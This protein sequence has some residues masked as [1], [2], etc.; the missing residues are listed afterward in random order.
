MGMFKFLLPAETPPADAEQYAHAY[1]QSGPEQTP[2]PTSIQ[3]TGS[4]L[5][6]ER[7]VDESAAFC[8]PWSIFGRGRLMLTTGT[9]IARPTPYCLSVE[10]ARGRVNL[11]RSQLN[12]WQAGGLQVPVA[13]HAQI[14]EINR[15]FARVV[16]QEPG[17][18]ADALAEVLLAK[19]LTA[20]DELV[21]LYVDQVLDARL[22][23]QLPASRDAS[24]RP[25][26]EPEVP[27]QPR[28]DTS[29]G[30]RLSGRPPDKEETDWFRTAFNTVQ[31]AIP[32]NE[33]EPEEG[34]IDWG[35]TDAVYAWAK[36]NGLA[37]V[38]GPVID[39]SS[40]SLPAWLWLY[41][42]NKDAILE[43]MVRFTSAAV[44]R[45]RAS[46]SVWE[47]TAAANST[48]VLS[49]SDEEA[50]QITAILLER[51]RRID[52][53]LQ[54][55]VGLSQPWG[56]YLTLP[57]RTY[58]ALSAAD[59]LRRTGLRIAGFDIEL[60][61]GIRPRGSYHRDLLEISRLLDV[62]ATVLGPPLRLTLGFP[63]SAERDPAADAEQQVVG[64]A[65]DVVSDEGQRRWAE[66]VALLTAA[67][68]YVSGVAWWHWSDAQ[69]H[70]APHSGLLAADGRPRPALDALKQLRR[71]FFL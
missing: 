7:D 11:L 5:L 18:E 54:L 38:A 25:H 70:L 53:N 60:L 67:K 34:R 1:L 65:S 52:A 68:P 31:I 29:W 9:L 3:Q 71:Q 6:V 41:E 32:W 8:V 33:I 26:A 46:A 63:A 42:D 2:W 69:P 21:Q 24:G 58:S 13:F 16:C 23:R 10:L 37:I 57:G 59:T 55:I 47:L 56:E 45:Y 49:L 22:S 19:A 12:D 35:Q 15:L 43:A 44:E 66:S 51:V 36:N 20:S 30:C 39:F 40:R 48:A 14:Q 64:D 62:Y 28:L 4:E 61:S 17:G 27:Y 50:L